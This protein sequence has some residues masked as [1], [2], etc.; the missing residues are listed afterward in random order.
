MALRL[1]EIVLPEDYDTKVSEA[2]KELHTI[3]IWV[4]L[5]LFFNIPTETEIVMK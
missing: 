3:G 4:N 2:V 5:F 1:L